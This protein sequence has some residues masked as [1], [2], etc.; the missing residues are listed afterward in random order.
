MSWILALVASWRFVLKHFVMACFSVVINNLIKTG[1]DHDQEFFL[2]KTYLIHTGRVQTH[3]RSVRKS[4][5]HCSHSLPW[6][7]ILRFKQ[8]FH[9]TSVKHCANDV[10]HNWKYIWKCIQYLSNCIYQHTLPVKVTISFCRE[11]GDNIVFDITPPPSSPMLTSKVST[12]IIYTFN[13]R[14]FE[15]LL[16]FWWS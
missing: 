10:V 4:V 9:E 2:F 13:E 6:V 12:Y 5:K 1:L 8:F 15:G 7:G 16:V 11:S 3:D 14:H